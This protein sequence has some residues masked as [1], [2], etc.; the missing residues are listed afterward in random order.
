MGRSVS[1]YV[2]HPKGGGV[3]KPAMGTQLQPHLSD[4]PC[5]LSVNGPV[6]MIHHH[7]I[8]PTE[9]W[10]L[11]PRSGGWSHMGAP[12]ALNG[13]SPDLRTG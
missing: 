6:M 1:E 7:P 13:G 3:S 12:G 10:S 11:K 8:L 5:A 9:A 4:K 2:P